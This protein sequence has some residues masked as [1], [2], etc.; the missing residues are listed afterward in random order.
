MNVIERG[1]QCEKKKKEEVGKRKWF[2]LGNL[3]E[4]KPSME[5]KKKK[6]ISTKIE[7]EIFMLLVYTLNIRF[8]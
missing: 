7:I 3:F 8:R 4:F 1:F 6:K 2:L 5:K